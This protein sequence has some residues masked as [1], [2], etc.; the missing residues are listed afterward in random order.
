MASTFEEI[1][2]SIVDKYAPLK[3][4]RVR[5][6]T[7]PWLNKSI[8]YLMKER[9][10]AKRTAQTSPEKWSVYKQLR[11][12]VTKTIKVAIETDYRRVI[13]DSRDIP[14]KMWKTINKVLDKSPQLTTTSSLDVE[15]I[16]LNGL[17]Q[18]R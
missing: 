18:N 11:K 6:E 7:A 2:E 9:D 4:R 13:D 15:G 12:K 17:L 1:F 10:L 8:R 3:K 5:S 16:S 14:K